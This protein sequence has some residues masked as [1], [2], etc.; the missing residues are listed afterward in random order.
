MKKHDVI[1]VGGGMAGLTAAT[2]LAKR[3]ID[4]LLIEKNDKCGGLVNSF[5]KDGF[6]FEGGVRALESAG[7]IIPMLKDLD[8]KLHTVKSPV[9]VGI[10]DRVIHVNS[11][12]NLKDYGNILKELYPDSIEDVEKL[13]KVIKHVMKNM[14]VLY[15]VENPV[16]KNFKSDKPYFVR[17]YLPWFFKFLVALWNINHMRIPVEEF[18]GKIIKNPSLK[19]IIDQHFF[20]GTP[21]FFAMSYFYLYTDY[22][23]FMGGV[24]KIAE[25]MHKKILEFG[26]TVAFET[27]IIEVDV[28]QKLLKDSEG[29]TYQYKELIWASDLKTLYRIA[30]T[31]NL[32]QAVKTKVELERSKILSRRGADS[33]YSVYMAVNEPPET[34]KKISHG[35]FFYT[36]SRKGMGETHRSELNSIL[37]NWSNFSKEDIFVWLDKFYQLNTYE[38]SIPVLKDPEAAPEGATGLIVST[39][40]E[41]DLIKKIEED[42]WYQEFKQEVEKRMIDVLTNSIYPMLKEKLLFSFSATPITIENTVASSEG[43]I[44]G[45]SFEETIPVT[46]SMIKINDSILTTFPHIKKAGQWSYSPT[47][48]PIAILTGKLAADAIKLQ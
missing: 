6:L 4:V 28:T 29:K 23:Y 3:G 8:I 41:Y 24:G 19:D 20:R 26:G 7:I 17:V 27:K 44:V 45:W 15:Q 34:F 32:P 42:G 13:L 16:F 9:S 33:V 31:E 47:G 25:N 2:Y 1:V 10:E 21:A 43:A 36:P 5:F 22:F 48:V 37:Q 35:H 30:A 40:F 18:L 39:L 38:I 14:K 12:K 11:E 46:S